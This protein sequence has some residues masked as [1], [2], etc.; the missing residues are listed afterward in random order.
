MNVVKG[1]SVNLYGRYSIIHDQ[2]NLPKGDITDEQLLLQKNEL[3]TQYTFW[4]SIGI[5]YTFGSIYNNIVN[6]RF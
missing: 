6:S 2:L 1:L 4:S 3:A 5:S